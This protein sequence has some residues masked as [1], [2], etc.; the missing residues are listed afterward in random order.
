MRKF[1]DAHCR[2]SRVALALA[3]IILAELPAVAWALPGY[4]NLINSFCR[5]QGATRVTYT[6]NGCTL[7]HHPGTFVSNPAH[8]VEP[9]WS[10]F[11]LGRS[12]GGD[13]SFYC[14][15][16]GSAPQLVLDAPSSSGSGVDSGPALD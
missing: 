4:A 16:S 6:D 1:G 15:P 3:A 14:P 5:A 13:Y 2:A 11:E 9:Q 7:C 12:A 10:E 8:R